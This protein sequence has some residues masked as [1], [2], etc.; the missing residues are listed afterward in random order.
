MGVCW[1]DVDAT[2]GNDGKA[3]SDPKA[4]IAA[5]VAVADADV[6]PVD[7]GVAPTRD[8][9]AVTIGADSDT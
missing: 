4:A 5:A 1:E 2:F 8:E 3:D 7:V 6:D 9:P